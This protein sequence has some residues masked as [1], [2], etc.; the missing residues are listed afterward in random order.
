MQD[1][2][3][4]EIHRL[5]LPVLHFRYTYTGGSQN[6]HIKM[7]NALFKQAQGWHGGTKEG[8]R[9]NK[10]HTNAGS[11]EKCKHYSMS[12]KIP[13]VCLFDFSADKKSYKKCF[14]IGKEM[15]LKRSIWIQT[16]LECCMVLK[17]TKYIYQLVWQ[18]SP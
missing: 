16:I 10:S 3:D 8:G 9:Q 1:S 12:K 11:L 5:P 2:A 14:Y 6:L 4:G 15:R 18:I 13:D 7:I 17:K